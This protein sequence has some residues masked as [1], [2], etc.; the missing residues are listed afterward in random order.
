ME[1]GSKF[2]FMRALILL[3][4]PEYGRVPVKEILASSIADAYEETS[5]ESADIQEKPIELHNILDSS[6]SN[7]QLRRMH[8][9]HDDQHI[10]IESPVESPIFESKSMS[11]S[12]DHA[13]S[14]PPK[15]DITILQNGLEICK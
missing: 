9:D 4:F 11:E 1:N 8:F 13:H 6:D 12:N 14:F 3:E 15:N 2:S 10:Y 7:R 5:S